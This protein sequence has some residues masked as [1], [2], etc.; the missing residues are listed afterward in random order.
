MTLVVILKHEIKSS[1]SQETALNY[2]QST[3]LS[4]SHQLPENMLSNIFPPSSVCSGES[5]LKWAMAFKDEQTDL[6]SISSIEDSTQMIEFVCVR[7]FNSV[8]TT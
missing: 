7:N 3:R 6:D 2:W 8:F 5:M 4:L 1:S